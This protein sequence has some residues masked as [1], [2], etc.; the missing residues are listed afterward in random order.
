MIKLK[1]LKKEIR[2]KSDLNNMWGIFT[3]K[4]NMHVC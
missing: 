1:S 4:W 2:I 3:V